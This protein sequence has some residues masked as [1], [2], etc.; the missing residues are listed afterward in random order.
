MARTR[1]LQSVSDTALLVAHHR[2][3]ETARP[4][5]LFRDPYAQRMA[6]E[7]GEEIARKLPWGKRMAWSTITRTVLMDEII[8]R[9]VGEGVDTVLNLAAG[10]DARPYRLELPASLR[11]I[12]MDLPAMIAAKNEMLAADK[13]HCQL[14][15]VSVNLADIDERRKALAAQAG[16]MRKA[17]VMTEGL[18]VYLNEK[19]VG[20]LACDLHS[21]P[22]IRY[23]VSDLAAPLVVKRM[24]RWWGKQ[25]KAANTWMDFAPAEGTKFFNPFGWREKEFNDLFE[26][27]RRIER[28]V[29]FAW[30]I[31]FQMKLFPKRAKKKI[32]LWR[33]GVA[34]LERIEA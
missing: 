22:T 24:Q 6:G 31:D 28:T 10:L 5:A 3:M 7:R 9:M 17:L 21:Q 32:A 30:L 12:E 8:T 34:L 26:N 16:R 4:D 13:P 19:T 29:P 33:T 15:R 25:M 20:E 27:S 11:W 18:L 2:A 14:E 1:I 23:W